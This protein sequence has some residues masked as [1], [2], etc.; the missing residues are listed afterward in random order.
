MADR[1][2][3]KISPETHERLTKSKP[4]NATWDGYLHHLLDAYHDPRP[5]IPRYHRTDD[6]NS[7]NPW[8]PVSHEERE[9]LAERARELQDEVNFKKL[10][11]ESGGTSEAAA[12]LIAELTADRVVEKLEAASDD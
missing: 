11:Q 5:R 9:E 10:L 3:I 6:D 12:S 2:N 4:D 1:K 8:E 7:G